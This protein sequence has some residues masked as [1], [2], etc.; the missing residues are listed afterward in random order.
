MAD[1]PLST[2]SSLYETRVRQSLKHGFLW[3]IQGGIIEEYVR[4]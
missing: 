1:T 3:R 4:F 2:R